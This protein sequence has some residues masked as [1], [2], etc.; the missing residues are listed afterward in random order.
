VVA[1]V[2]IVAVLVVLMVDKVLLE[3]GSLDK[4]WLLH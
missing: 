1:V 4:I 2:A 3:F